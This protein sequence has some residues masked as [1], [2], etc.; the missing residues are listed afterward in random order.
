MEK[1]RIPPI[2]EGRIRLRLIEETDLPMTLKWRNQDHIRKWFIN[3]EIISTEQ[4][5][6]W[7][8]KYL[9]RNDDYLFIIEETRDLQQPIGQISI[10]NIDWEQ[11][12]GEYGRLLIG[13]PKAR[14]KGIAKEATRLLLAYAFGQL[15]F[16][17]IHLVVF[18]NN[19]PAIHIYQDIGFCE[20]SQMDRLKT[21]SIFKKN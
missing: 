17:E 2:E 11:R 14:S 9:E 18:D 12:Y 10:Y 8:Q 20:L 3:P 16:E 21:M 13:E 7:F 15:R 1:R 5:W 4:H 6:E 19:E